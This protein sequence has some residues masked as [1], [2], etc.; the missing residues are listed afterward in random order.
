MAKMK[1]GAAR[2]DINQLIEKVSSNDTNEVYKSLKE[3][4]GYFKKGHFRRTF[5][6]RDGINHLSSQLASLCLGHLT[7]SQKQQSRSSSAEAQDF[8]Q[9]TGITKTILS[10]LKRLMNESK[11]SREQVNLRHLQTNLI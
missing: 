10:C 5:I 8:A 3:L 11:V 7:E 2:V 4:H 1:H 9:G 6:D